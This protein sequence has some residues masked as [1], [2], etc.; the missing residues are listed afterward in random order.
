VAKAVSVKEAKAL[1]AKKISPT[2]I[3]CEHDIIDGSWKAILKHARN[4]PNKPTVVVCSR[5]ADERLWVEVLNLGAFDL[6]LIAP[7]VRDELV[8]VIDSAHRA[9]VL[10]KEQGER[11][12]KSAT[13]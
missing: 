4:L 10:V 2:V 9:C 1:L 8:R 12:K 13:I 7:V 3:L 5:C 11:K 6:L